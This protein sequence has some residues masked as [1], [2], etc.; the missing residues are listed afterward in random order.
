MITC[1]FSVA[2]TVMCYIAVIGKTFG[3]GQVVVVV[4]N[5]DVF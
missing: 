2:I 1:E 3:M 4:G 5:D